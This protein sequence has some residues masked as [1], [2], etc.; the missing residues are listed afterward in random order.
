MM[1]YIVACWPCHKM[2]AS[3]QMPLASQPGQGLGQI[4]VAPDSEG[5]G[6]HFPLEG[7]ASI[8]RLGWPGDKMGI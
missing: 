8:L 6:W 2:S 1:P 4:A 7:C 3:V 5:S